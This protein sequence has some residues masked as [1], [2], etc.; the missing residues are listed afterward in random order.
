MACFFRPDLD[1]AASR[2]PTTTAEHSA[3]TYSHNS[4]QRA[5]ATCH[6]TPSPLARLLDMISVISVRPV[7]CR[8]YHDDDDDGDDRST[9][10]NRQQTNRPT[11][12]TSLPL[13]PTLPPVPTSPTP[14]FPLPNTPLILDLALARTGLRSAQTPSS[15][16]LTSPRTL[17]FCLFSLFTPPAIGCSPKLPPQPLALCTRFP[18]MDAL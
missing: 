2:E 12:Q 7:G 18:Q 6:V 14:P 3:F 13:P 1:P 15:N 8:L 5:Y 10:P 17:H 4:N 9:I 11:D 16:W